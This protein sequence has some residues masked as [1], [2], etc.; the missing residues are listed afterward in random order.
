MSLADL[1]VWVVIQPAHL[2]L[3]IW[4]TARTRVTR[5]EDVR[6]TN[7]ANYNHRKEAAIGLGPGS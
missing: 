6:A 3:T 4:L 1:R 5:G 2:K 7:V